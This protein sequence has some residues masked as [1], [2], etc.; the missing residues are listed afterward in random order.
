[1]MLIKRSV[2]YYFRVGFHTAFINAK[3]NVDHGPRHEAARQCTERFH[4]L[5]L[6]AWRG[7]GRT[8]VKIGAKS[9]LP[10]RAVLQIIFLAGACGAAHAASETETSR[11]ELLYSTHCIACHTAQ[12]HWRGKRLATDWKSL[13]HQ[14]RRWQNNAHLGWDED[15][16]SEVTRYLNRLYYHFPTGEKQNLGS[17][18]GGPQRQSPLPAPGQGHL[19]PARWT[20]D[21]GNGDAP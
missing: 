9:M 21:A 10:Y 20:G 11:G 7:W 5:V 1:M 14:V 19:T 13:V 12:A 3:W 15:D 2:A 6:R 16:I 18:Q 8:D 17:L 4:P